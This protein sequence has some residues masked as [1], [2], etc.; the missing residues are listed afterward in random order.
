VTGD[1]S[2]TAF[3]IAYYRAL[4]SEAPDAIVRDCH[5]RALAGE[6]GRLVL[7][8]LPIA[9]RQGWP[10]AVRTRVYDDMI[11]RAVHG[12]EVDAVLSLG[13]GLDARPYRLDLPEALSWVEADLPAIIDYKNGVLSSAVPSCSVERCAV[14]L[15]DVTARRALLERVAREHDRVFV[16]TEGFLGHLDEHVVSAMAAE[17]RSLPAS[18][19]WAAEIVSPSVLAQ[20]RV[21]DTLREAKIGLKFA[22]AQGVDFFVERGWRPRCVLSFLDEARRLWRATE[23]LA[24]TPEQQNALRNAS[25]YL[26]LESTDGDAVRER[27]W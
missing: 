11:L 2:D 20:A 13:A 15:A 19:L 5:A 21:V 14:D 3:L 4:E 12:G 25:E 18:R 23:L 6:R 16:L 8:G 10:I 22:P 17:L 7:E 1:I 24:G 27:S 26:L 9:M